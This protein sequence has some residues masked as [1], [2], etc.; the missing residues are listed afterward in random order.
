MPQAKQT[1]DEILRVLDEDLK[2]EEEFEASSG[3]GFLRSEQ[4]E[5]HSADDEE[6]FARLNEIEVRAAEGRRRRKELLE[7]HE[8][9]SGK[10]FFQ[11]II[12]KYE[13]T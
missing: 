7:K 12:D 2:A 11:Q 8:E 6:I 13:N 10:S 9:T 3:A 4:T 1:D 5:D